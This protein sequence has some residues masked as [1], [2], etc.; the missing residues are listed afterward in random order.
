MSYFS[1]TGFDIRCEWGERGASLLAPLSDVAIIVDVLSFSTCVDI[2]TARRTEIL[3]YRWKDSRAADFAAAN[4]AVLAVGRSGGGGERGR[5]TLS[6]LSMQSVPAG[7]RIVLPS[8]NGSA[9]SVCT[10]NVPTLCGC[11]R[12]CRAVANHANRTGS[13]IVVVPAGE[14]WE[15]GSLRPS[16]EDLIGAGAI[17]KYLKGGRSPEADL[18]VAAFEHAAGD[19]A[20]RLLNCSSGR[21]LADKGYQADV[22]LSA[23]YD[24]SESVPMLKD[25][26]YIHTD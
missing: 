5:Y 22:A 10:G 6:P 25:G 7:L 9:L 8:P 4:N 3:P 24:C 14:R 21:E 19:L 18:A 17:I 11:L 2:A 23:A 15:D 26:A 20:D 16:A 12:N 13:K 1:Q